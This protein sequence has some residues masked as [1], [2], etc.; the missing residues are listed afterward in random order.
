MPQD[1]R[2]RRGAIGPIG[3]T[4]ET[5]ATGPTGSPGPNPS[6]TAGF[7][8]N[9][10]EAVI[11]TLLRTVLVPS[12]NRH[13]LSSDIVLNRFNTVFTANTPGRYR[14]SCQMNVTLELLLRSRLLINGSAYTPS[15]ISPMPSKASFHNEVIVDLASSSTVTLELYGLLGTVI[16]LKNSIGASFQLGGENSD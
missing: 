9:T 15:V 13:V 2:A 6:S 5:G 4:G 1:Q 3:P 16:L 8:A 14:I 7:A 12:P 10:S 11:S